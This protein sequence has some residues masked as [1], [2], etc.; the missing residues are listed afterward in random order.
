MVRG[1]CASSAAAEGTE[2]TRGV[3]RQRSIAL[4][5]QALLND[6]TGEQFRTSSTQGATSTQARS[7]SFIKRRP[8]RSGM[9]IGMASGTAIAPAAAGNE[10][11]FI[12]F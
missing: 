4:A 3:L 7:R 12:G 2:P 9:L 11:A 8:V 10:A 6:V 5:G 1:L